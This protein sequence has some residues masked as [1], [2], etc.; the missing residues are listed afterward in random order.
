MG[1]AVK[2]VPTFRCVLNCNEQ[3]APFENGSNNL[4]FILYNIL[5]HDLFSQFCFFV[6]SC[7][8]PRNLNW[9]IWKINQDTFDIDKSIKYI[10][11]VIPINPKESKC[12]DKVEQNRELLS[13]LI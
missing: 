13:F 7:F 9:W 3:A 1:F 8:A 6:M 4:K 12:P 5:C 2:Y 11:I 10:L